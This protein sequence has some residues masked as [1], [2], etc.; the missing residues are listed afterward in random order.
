MAWRGWVLFFLSAVALLQAGE[1]GNAV[2]ETVVIGSCA[3]QDGDQAFW[4]SIR[5]EKPDLFLFIG[6]NIYAD[7]LK[8]R[9]LKKQYKKLGRS[10]GFAALRKETRLMAVWDDHDYGIN[11]GGGDYALKHDS[12][13]AFLRFFKP[14]KDTRVWRGP[15]L[16][17]R[18]TFGPEGQRVQVIMLDTRFFRSGWNALPKDEWGDQGRYLTDDNPE[19]TML[20][21]AQWQ[22]L[23][24]CLQEPADLRLV[25]TSI[26]AVSNDHRWEKWGNFPLERAKLFNS[27][28]QSG[29]KGVVLISGD[30]HSGEVSKLPA[31]D[32]DGVGYPLYE[33]TSSGLNTNMASNPDEP[34]RYRIGTRRLVNH[35]AVLTIDWRDDPE[36]AMQ[37]KSTEGE[38][39]GAPVRVPLSQLR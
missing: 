33:M 32:A 21:K 4:E 31:D 22:W 8:Y 39:L 38:N 12:K 36:I 14:P 16:Y 28:K 24:R 5:Q 18:E 11:D 10:P 35:Y 23:V 30:R 13:K 26:Q 3:K 2:I 20:G 29:A 27:I 15:G 37:F 9:K 19:K 25:I 1:R 6:D 17:H 34:N 7:E